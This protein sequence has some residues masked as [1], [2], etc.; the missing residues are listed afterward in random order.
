M[1]QKILL[2][3]GDNR[4]PKQYGIVQIERHYFVCRLVR[5]EK[6]EVLGFGRLIGANFK[7]LAQAV[8]FL[9]RFTKR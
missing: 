7:D 9:I 4:T 5:N 3:H 2:W 8:R 1:S 6:G